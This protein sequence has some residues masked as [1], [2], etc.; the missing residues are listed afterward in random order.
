MR[1]IALTRTLLVDD[2]NVGD[3]DIE[4]V[5][6]GATEHNMGGIG[7]IAPIFMPCPCTAYLNRNLLRELCCPKRPI[8]RY[9]LV[10][11][12]HREWRRG[13]VGER[14]IRLPRFMIGTIG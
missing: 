2:G 3:S 7:Y 11:R 4:I 14:S 5:L 13:K 8:K 1:S 10:E 9:K 12:I 6:Y